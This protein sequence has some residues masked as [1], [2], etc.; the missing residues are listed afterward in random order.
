LRPK[1]Q[2]M[3]D[4]KT[5]SNSEKRWLVREIENGRMTVGEAKERI[6]IYSKDP[7]VTSLPLRVANFW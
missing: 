4:K 7:Q 3:E 5:I 2:K 1:P 6:E